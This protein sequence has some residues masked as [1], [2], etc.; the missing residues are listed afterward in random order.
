MRP[1]I[2]RVWSQLR[3]RKPFHGE[4]CDAF[5]CHVQCAMSKD[6]HTEGQDTKLL[7]P[8]LE[9]GVGDATTAP[10]GVTPKRFLTIQ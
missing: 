9:Q 3:N 1:R 6:A 5:R 10:P 4:D 8:A 7:N 2:A